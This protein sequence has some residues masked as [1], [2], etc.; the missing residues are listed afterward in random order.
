[1]WTKKWIQS[2]LLILLC[3]CCF[4]PA[5]VWSAHS[6]SDEVLCDSVWF[7]WLVAPQGL[8]T[9]TWHTVLLFRIQT[10][11]HCSKFFF[12]VTVC[13]CFIQN[14]IFLSYWHYSLDDLVFHDR[15]KQFPVLILKLFALHYAFNTRVFG[16]SWALYC[17]LH[18]H[19]FHPVMC[20]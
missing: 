1:M 11:Y 9:Q 14:N 5:L 20:F 18:V 8:C 7:C 3:H 2:K 17:F 13:N 4:N 10:D 19:C 12:H 15:S 6:S 16:F